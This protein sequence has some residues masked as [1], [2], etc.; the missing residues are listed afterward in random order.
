[1]LHQSFANY[2]GSN[3]HRYLCYYNYVNDGGESVHGCQK[4]FLSIHDV[5]HGHVD[6]VLRGVKIERW[7]SK[8]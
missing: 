4:A 1:M 7:Y 5:S 3:W 8:D 2:G 6:Q